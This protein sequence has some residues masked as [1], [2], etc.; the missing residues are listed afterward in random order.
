MFC[1]YPYL[2]YRCQVYI[3]FKSAQ[4]TKEDKANS[5]ILKFG[6]CFSGPTFLPFPEETCGTHFSESISKIRITPWLKGGY[7]L[8]QMT[9]FILIG[10]ASS[11]PI[12][13]FILQLETIS[14]RQHF[15]PLSSFS[16]ARTKGLKV[17][18]RPSFRSTTVYF[19]PST[20]RL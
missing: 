11:I 3:I 7:S 19:F 13:D 1:Y 8:K 9:K 6:F 12:P 10:Y 15:V 2:S 16:C 17:L 4:I 5:K 18:L 14:K 20:K